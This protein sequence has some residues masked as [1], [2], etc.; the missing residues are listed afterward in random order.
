[1]SHRYRCERTDCKDSRE[2]N[3]WTDT[4]GEWKIDGY[5]VPGCCARSRNQSSQRV[6][7]PMEIIY[8]DRFNQHVKKIQI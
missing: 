2:C 6:A 8:P 5:M 3:Y 7:K 1:M 4:S